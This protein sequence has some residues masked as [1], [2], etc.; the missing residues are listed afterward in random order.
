MLAYMSNIDILKVKRGVCKGHTQ[1]QKGYLRR[2]PSSSSEGVFAQVILKVRGGVCLGVQ[3]RHPQGQK[4]CLRRC[5]SSRS[6]G[7]FAKVSILKVR[8]GVC[9]GHLQ[10]QKGCLPRWRVQRLQFYPG[11]IGW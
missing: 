11:A 9:E 8:R 3:H 5:P 7:V 10:G 1:G 2:S 4:G 6:E